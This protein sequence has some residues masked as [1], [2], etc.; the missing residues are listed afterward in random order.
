[1]TDKLAVIAMSP[2]VG[3]SVMDRLGEIGVK[4][5]LYFAPSAVNVPENM[6]VVNQDVSIDLGILTYHITNNTEQRP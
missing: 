1:M 4:G 2:R 6:V 3:Q 5:V